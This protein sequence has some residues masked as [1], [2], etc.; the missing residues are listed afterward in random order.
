MVYAM[1]Y[2]VVWRGVVW[3]VSMVYDIPYL[4]KNGIPLSLDWYMAYAGAL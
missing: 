4:R 3:C 2:G 1:L